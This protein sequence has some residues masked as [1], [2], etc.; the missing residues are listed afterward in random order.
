MV[1]LRVTDDEGE[2]VEPG[3]PDNPQQWAGSSFETELKPGEELVLRWQDADWFD[4]NDWGYKLPSSERYTIEGIPLVG[5][6]EL[7]QD[8]KNVR[9]NRATIT[10]R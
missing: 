4:L 10:V 8:D 5:G 6:S 7:R 1:E 3:T 2:L 9:S